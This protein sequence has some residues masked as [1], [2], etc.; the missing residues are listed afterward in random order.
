MTTI[1][2]KSNFHQLIDAIQD[3]RMLRDLYNCVRFAAATDFAVNHDTKMT[4]SQVIRMKESLKQIE[5]GQTVSHKQV[6]ENLRQ[7]LTR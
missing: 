2:I 7:W 6:Q 1:E 3:D 4:E 5:N